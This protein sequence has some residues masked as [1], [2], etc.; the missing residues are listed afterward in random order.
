[1]K[2]IITD[3]TRFAEGKDKVC[4]AGIDIESQAKCLR[5]IPYLPKSKI[6]D[7]SIVPGE[8]LEGIF[9][10]KKVNLPHVEDVRYSKLKRA[11]PCKSKDFEN[12][13]QNSTHPTIHD[14]FDKKIPIG[15]HYIPLDDPPSKSIITLCLHPTQI[16]LFLDYWGK[17]KLKIT[18]N[19]GKIYNYMPITDLGFFLHLSSKSKSSNNI[20]DI[21]KFIWKQ[22]KLFLRIGLSRYYESPGGKNGF[23]LQVNGIYTFPQYLLAVRTYE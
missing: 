21:N 4:I 19:D 17:F 20:D 22:K 9:D 3:L 8:I 12:V 14:G 10:D 18:D 2:L 7:L 23:W 1:L 11:G 16:K 6:I 5:P 13:L 15:E